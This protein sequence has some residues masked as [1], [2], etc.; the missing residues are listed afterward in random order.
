MGITSKRKIH[1]KKNVLTIKAFE[2][3]CCKD[4]IEVFMLAII[5]VVLPDWSFLFD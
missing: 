4:I 2:Y 5:I 1:L 3:N